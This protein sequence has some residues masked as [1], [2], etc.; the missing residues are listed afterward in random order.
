[1][2]TLPKTWRQQLRLTPN[3]L[4]RLQGDNVFGVSGLGYRRSEKKPLSA[5]L[6]R[7]I[8]VSPL[9]AFEVLSQLTIVRADEVLREIKAMH[10]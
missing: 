8:V 2:L 9:S 7:K 3:P 1:M 4:S 5:A 6:R 10:N